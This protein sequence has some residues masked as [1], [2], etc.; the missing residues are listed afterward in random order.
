M[1]GEVGRFGVR[2]QS[3]RVRHDVRVHA[4]E[5]GRL[6]SEL[7]PLVDGDAVAGDP[8]K[9]H[10]FR[11]EPLDETGEASGALDVFGA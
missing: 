9:A 8:D 3:A 1:L 10:D 6:P 7:G 5:A 2:V 4:G 11:G